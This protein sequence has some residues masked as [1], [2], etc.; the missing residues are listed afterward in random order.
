MAIKDQQMRNAAFLGI[1]SFLEA[2]QLLVLLAFIASFIPIKVAPFVQ[3]LFPLSLY[4]VR[5]EREMLLYRTW[6]IS[7]ITIQAGLMFFHR[8]QIGEAGLSRKLYPFALTGAVLLMAQAF[9]IFKA[10]LLKAVVAKVVLGIVIVVAYLAKV[11]WPEIERFGAALT[12]QLSKPVLRPK[13]WVADIGFLVL[14]LVFIAPW[15]M[16]R[17]MSSVF[18][19]DQCYHLDGTFMTAAWASIKGLVLEKDVI[20]QYSTVMPPLVGKLLHHTVGFSYMSVMTFMVVLVLG[21]YAA[22]FLFLRR[23]LDSFGAAAVA[24]ILT[25]KLQMFHWGVS[26][27]VWLY[28]SATPL[29]HFADI[30]F[31]IALWQHLRTGRAAWLYAAAAAVGF[32]FSW[33]IDVGL[34]MAAAL[35]VYTVAHGYQQQQGAGIIFST[36]AKALTLSA[37]T[38]FGILWLFNGAGVVSAEFWRNMTEHAALFLQGWGALPMDDGLKDRQFFAFF[39][40]FAIPVFYAGVLLTQAALIY[41]RQGGMQQ[42]FITVLC[43]YGLGLY[44]YFIHRS[45]VT[46]YYAVC[47]PLVMIIAAGL[48]HVF[49]RMKKSHYRLAALALGA[50]ALIAL[51]TGYLYSFYPNPFNGRNPDWALQERFFDEKFDFKDDAALVRRLTGAGER[52]AI[53]SSF[54]TA[55]LMA[56]DRAPFFYYSPMIESS[57]FDGPKVRLSYLHT[58]PRLQKTLQSLQQNKPRYI[59]VQERLLGVQDQQAL[60]ALLG[61][62]QA[63]YTAG[64][65]SAHLIAFERKNI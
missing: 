28:V 53:V 11:F 3:Q 62:V 50:W 59:F 4:D 5:P 45:G 43:I 54:E 32:A 24:I 34:Y 46:S 44:H 33:M 9:L 38:A 6:A 20:S 31:F 16:H 29:R 30:I 40:G 12:Q 25:V 36:T 17:V 2:T 56:A 14:L 41:L 21:Y 13:P 8:R 35:G 39:L 65:R 18:L 60:G 19:Y 49:G 7:A 37:A 63:N 15:G 51:T 27:M 52:V 23:W 58:V 64:P 42:V 1:I 26:P 61:Y 48:D 47:V 55:I 57:H 10:L 22:L